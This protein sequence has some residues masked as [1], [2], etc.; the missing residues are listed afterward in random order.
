MVPVETKNMNIMKYNGMNSNEKRA[1]KETEKNTDFHSS[2]FFPFVIKFLE[3]HVEFG[4]SLCPYILSKF[5]N[6]FKS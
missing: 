1:N 4:S 5:I 6:Y 2:A 3:S